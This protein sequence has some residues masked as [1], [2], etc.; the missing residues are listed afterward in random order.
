MPAIGAVTEDQ[1]AVAEFDAQ[2]EQANLPDDFSPVISEGD[3]F[4]AT[5]GSSSSAVTDHLSDIPGVVSDAD[6][7]FRIWAE[8][9]RRWV[10]LFVKHGVKYSI[11]DDILSAIEAPFVSFKTVFNNV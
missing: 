10:D 2:I 11:M 1:L 6:S 3:Y 9:N 5:D 7:R 8:E 4:N